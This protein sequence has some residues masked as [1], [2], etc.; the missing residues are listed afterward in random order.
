MKKFFFSLNTVLD[1]K[2][3]VLESLRAEHATALA[4]VHECEREIE[5]LE[6]EHR[7]CSEELHEK[8]CRGIKVNEIYTYE[9]YL[10]SIGVK[11]KKKLEELERLQEIA[12]R[13]KE[14]V[15]EARK[16]TASIE[17]LRE[18]KMD[19]YRKEEQKEQEQLVEEFVSTRSAMEK[20]YG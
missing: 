19:E 20:I 13:K 4:K 2:Q 11:I 6:E 18:H 9:Y 12:E 7:S 3:Q 16:E 14:A 8:R 15:V 1:Y 5:K 10:E 17:K